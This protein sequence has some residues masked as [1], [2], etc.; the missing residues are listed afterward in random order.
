M[1]PSCTQEI[2]DED[3]NQWLQKIIIISLFCL[4]MLYY[5]ISCNVKVLYCKDEV[6]KWR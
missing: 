2:D 3:K 1:L 5:L 4:F 6:E